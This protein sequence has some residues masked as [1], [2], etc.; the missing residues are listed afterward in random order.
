ME[1]AQVVDLGWCPFCGGKFKASAKTKEAF[2]EG[3]IFRIHRDEYREFAERGMLKYLESPRSGWISQ[4]TMDLVFLGAT[5][6]IGI[7]ILVIAIH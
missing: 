6:P 1:T 2:F 7:A 3:R 5:I 4:D